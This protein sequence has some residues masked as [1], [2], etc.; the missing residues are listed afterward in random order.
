[1]LAFSLFHWGQDISQLAP[2]VYFIY[3]SRSHGSVFKKYEYFGTIYN[4]SLKTLFKE[5]L[6]FTKHIFSWRFPISKF[7]ASFQFTLSPKSNNYT[8]LTV[9]I[10]SGTTLRA[11]LSVCEP[12]PP[13]VTRS[14]KCKT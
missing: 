2:P 6:T 1:M 14:T 8:V 5:T 7:F 12:L 4:S 9:V 13:F 10:R 11:E 3:W